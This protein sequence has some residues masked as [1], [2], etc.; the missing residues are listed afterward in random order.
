MADVMVQPGSALLDGLRM[1]ELDE[2]MAWVSKLSLV[3]T[4]MPCSTLLSSGSE[5]AESGPPSPPA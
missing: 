2:P 4:L 3:A 5:R 1:T